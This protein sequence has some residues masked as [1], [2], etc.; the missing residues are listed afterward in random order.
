MKEE[1]KDH[2][3]IETEKQQRGLGNRNTICYETQYRNCSN[4]QRNSW[5]GDSIAFYKI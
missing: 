1:R 5:F 2:K 3:E 4:L